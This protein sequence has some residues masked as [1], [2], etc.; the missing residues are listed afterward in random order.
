MLLDM[1]HLNLV[2]G[3]IQ[4]KT[5]TP[6]AALNIQSKDT[7]KALVHFYFFLTQVHVHVVSTFFLVVSVIHKY[8]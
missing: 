3:S 8:M 5:S 4:T 2:E 6:I 1:S 7:G